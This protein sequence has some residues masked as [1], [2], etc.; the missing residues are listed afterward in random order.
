MYPL[1]DI[2]R[3]LEDHLPLRPAP[4]GHDAAHRSFLRLKETHELEVGRGGH[5][6]DRSD[7]LPSIERGKVFRYKILRTLVLREEQAGDS[8]QKQ[9]LLERR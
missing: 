8:N 5:R 1:S 9:S 6:L 2:F 3:Q 4:R 7:R